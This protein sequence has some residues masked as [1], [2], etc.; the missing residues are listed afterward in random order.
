V[1]AREDGSTVLIE[2]SFG[3]SVDADGA[4]E[5]VYVEDVTDKRWNELKASLVTHDVVLDNQTKKLKLKKRK[6]DK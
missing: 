1:Q 2:D 3:F 6:E 5:P 4:G